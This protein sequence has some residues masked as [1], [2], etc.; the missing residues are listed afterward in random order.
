MYILH[1]SCLGKCDE[2]DKWFERNPEMVQSEGRQK[3]VRKGDRS[4]K[5]QL[6]K[7]EI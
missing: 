1:R 3:V 7:S 4:P 2:V 6:G 5:W